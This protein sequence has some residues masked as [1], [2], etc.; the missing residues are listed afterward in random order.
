MI[1]RHQID[2]ASVLARK[3]KA[4]DKIQEAQGTTAGLQPD[5]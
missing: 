1:F 3:A 2:A 5:D 4:C